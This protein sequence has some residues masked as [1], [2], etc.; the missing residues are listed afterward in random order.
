MLSKIK[1]IAKMMIVKTAPS[2]VL[3]WTCISS[4]ACSANRAF[5]FL[6]RFE[7][8]FFRFGAYAFS[9]SFS[10]IIGLIKFSKSVQ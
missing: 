1:Y 4:A 9:A 5:S 8:I 6:R 10:E 7:F 3:D 2:L